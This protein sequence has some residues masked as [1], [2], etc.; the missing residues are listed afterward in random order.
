[1]MATVSYRCIRIIPILTYPPPPPK[2]NVTMTVNQRDIV[3]Q[4]KSFEI[5][6]LCGNGPG[7]SRKNRPALP[8]EKES[9]S[10]IHARGG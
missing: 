6:L 9:S 10:H 5:L 4:V 1:M 7:L 3:A 2:A 8:P